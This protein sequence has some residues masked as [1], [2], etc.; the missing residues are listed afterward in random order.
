MAESKLYI[1]TNLPKKEFSEFQ[2]IKKSPDTYILS[3]DYSNI[4]YDGI[5]SFI[6]YQDD[7]IYH[8]SK[9]FPFIKKGDGNLKILY[10][11]NDVDNDLD[12]IEVDFFINYDFIGN[13]KSGEKNE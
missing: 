1:E 11:N 12:N 13:T 6:I 5:V 2:I 4:I 10:H 8:Q 7:Q 3:F 9:N